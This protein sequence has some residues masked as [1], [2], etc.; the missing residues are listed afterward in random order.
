MKLLTNITVFNKDIDMIPLMLTIASQLKYKTL[1]RT[2][3]VHVEATRA[4]QHIMT[5]WDCGESKP[6]KAL[7]KKI[8]ELAKTLYQDINIKVTFTYENDIKSN[9]KNQY[10]ESCMMY[11]YKEYRENSDVNLDQQFGY[12]TDE[13]Y[14]MRKIANQEWSRYCQKKQQQEHKKLHEKSKQ[15][16]MWEYLEQHTQYMLT[17]TML[18]NDKVREAARL[19]VKYKGLHDEQFRLFDLKNQSVNYL[20]KFKKLSED[21]VLD[22]ANI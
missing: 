12:S 15:V 14:N 3:G 20:Y 7:N 13:I 18:P 2:Q 6:Y 4:H 11:P 21:E 5:I 22:I 1:R 16:G 19:I 8:N 9:P 17:S 10:N